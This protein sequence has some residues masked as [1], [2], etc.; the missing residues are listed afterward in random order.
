[1][2]K[3]APPGRNR[4]WKSQKSDF[5]GGVCRRQRPLVETELGFGPQGAQGCAGWARNPK[6]SQITP[7]C[8]QLGRH[9]T[10]LDAT[11]AGFRQILARRSLGGS[12]PLNLNFF[13]PFWSQKMSKCQ[14]VYFF[15]NGHPP[16]RADLGP[17]GAQGA[18]GQA[19][20]SCFAL[21]G[22]PVVPCLGLVWPG[23]VLP[24][25]PWSGPA[26]TTAAAKPPPAAEGGRLLLLD[27][28]KARQARQ[29]KAKPSQ[30]KARHNKQ[31]NLRS[32]AQGWH[33]RS[34]ARSCHLSSQQQQWWQQ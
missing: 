23:P 30:A 2:P 29:A 13:P 11:S 28:A 25:L 7:F 12:R 26:T 21:A 20:N 27:Q 3:A 24:A 33:L 14:F 9:P 32:Q 16:A 1:M 15:E 22:L 8:H 6:G 10:V 17:H 19:P 34:Q 4:A 18:H 31:A 5:W